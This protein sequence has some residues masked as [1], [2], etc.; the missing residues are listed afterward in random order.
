MFNKYKQDTR[1]SIT[2][3]FTLNEHC[4]WN[5]WYCNQGLNKKKNVLNLTKYKS[6][7]L[8]FKNEIIKHNIPVT[9][10]IFMGGEL[11]ILPNL[12]EYFEDISKYID[13]SRDVTFIIVTN[14]SCDIITYEKLFK[15]LD[16][17]N[18]KAK[19]SVSAHSMYIDKTFITKI[20]C[21]KDHI[22]L[23]VNVVGTQPELVKELEMHNIKYEINA[24]EFD[25]EGIGSNKMCNYQGYTI[26]PNAEIVDDCSQESTN[27]M[28]FKIEALNKQCN[29]KCPSCIKSHKRYINMYEI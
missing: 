29:L 15:I 8:K 1:Q 9:D 25:E 7:L 3:L 23:T 20:N 2:M 16:K 21:I 11:C 5:C 28:K 22:D 26:L 13:M 24:I 19:L 4:N 10:Y 14:F 12:N 6:I 27:Y 18:I 17:Q